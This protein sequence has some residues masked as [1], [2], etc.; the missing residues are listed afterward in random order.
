MNILRI[1]FFEIYEKIKLRDCQGVGRATN[2]SY[3]KR[4][5][6]FYS[7]LK[8]RV[9][10]ILI[11]NGFKEIKKRRFV[12]FNDSDID[13]YEFG[14]TKKLNGLKVSYG[15]ISLNDTENDKKLT[16]S[17]SLDSYGQFGKDWFYLKPKF[18]N[19]DYEYPVRK[20]DNMDDKMIM[21]IA[22]LI[23][24]T[25]AKENKNYR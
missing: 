15:S 16:A 9:A 1:V 22:A 17:H 8:E 24:D 19:Y 14:L 3:P 11:Q 10:P 12:K 18:W 21:E 7:K 5:D 25:L 20:N 13:F 6:V 23:K 4:N 2:F